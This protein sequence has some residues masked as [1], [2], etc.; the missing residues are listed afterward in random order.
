MVEI[1]ITK[2]FF[3]WE[4]EWIQ[5]LILNN[6]QAHVARNRFTTTIY[7]VALG[8]IVF[9]LVSFKL[10]IELYES[11]N[12]LKHGMVPTLDSWEECDLNPKY[13]DPV[14]KKHEQYI[15]SWTYVTLPGHKLK[16][17]GGVRAT[18]PARLRQFDSFLFG[19]Q[20]GIFNTT[21]MTYVDIEMQHSGLMIGEQLYTASG[22]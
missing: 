6:L 18:D 21:T 15:E 4:S 2:L 10:Q 13:I 3:F 20:P 19:V 11:S 12:Y 8:F 22:S 9:L 14:I 17:F 5:K 7:S 1:V 16:P